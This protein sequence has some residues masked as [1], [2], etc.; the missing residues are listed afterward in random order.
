MRSLNKIEQ[1]RELVEYADQDRQLTIQ[2]FQLQNKYKRILQIFQK[3]SNA[4]PDK[5]LD[6]IMQYKR[7][8]KEIESAVVA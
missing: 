5:K 1:Q 2:V 4:E 6:T 7:E 3:I 8:M